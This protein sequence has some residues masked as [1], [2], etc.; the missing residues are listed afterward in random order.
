MEV[1]IRSN[2]SNQSFL[3]FQKNACIFYLLFRYLNGTI[4][5]VQILGGQ[6]MLLGYFVHD[7]S[8]QLLL[9]ASPFGYI[10]VS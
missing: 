6:F 3:L 4:M 9:Y 7:L 1:A 2:I 8:L 10:S 5:F